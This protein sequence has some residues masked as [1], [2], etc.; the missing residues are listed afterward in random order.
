VLARTLG[1]ALAL[2]FMASAPAEA[3]VPEKMLING[4]QV[5][6]YSNRPLAVRN[7]GVSRAVIVIHGSGRKVE[8]YFS[9]IVDNIPSSPD[10]NRD[11]RRK[12][13][14]LAPYFQEKDDTK[15]RGAEKTEAWWKDD[16]VTGGSSGGVSSYEVIDTLVARLR[17]GTF[18]NLR[19]VVITG[20]SAG[21]QFVQRYAAFTDIDQQ[22]EPNASLV[23]FVPSNPSSYV[24]LNEYRYN[25]AQNDWVIPHG[26][27][28]KGYDDFKYGLE[29]LE[30]YAEARGADWARTHLPKRRIELLAGTADV[31]ADPSFDDSKEAM[32]QGHSRYERAKLFDAFM[33]RF[34]APNNFRVTP[35]PGVGHDH[36]LIYASAQGRNAL[37][38]SD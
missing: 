32:W 34:F 28:S 9:S 18:P 23:K 5:P 30:D 7:T 24:Y 35:V 38:F 8:D 3:G 33:D 37:Y 10:P 20:H 16:W 1:A 17:S 12:T 25:G 4:K 29:D 14:V 19:W 21:G 31:V 6:Y 36:R 15:N 27:K 11:W 13:I 2:T 22:S 26:K